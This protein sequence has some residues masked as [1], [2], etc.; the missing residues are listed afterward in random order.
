MFFLVLQVAP[1]LME[2]PQPL[3]VLNVAGMVDMIKVRSLLGLPN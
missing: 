1:Q 3:D 2:V